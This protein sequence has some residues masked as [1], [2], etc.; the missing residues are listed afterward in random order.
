M[1]ITGSD[2]PSPTRLRSALCSVSRNTT[3]TRSPV[4][5]VCAWVGPRPVY[6]RSSRTTPWLIACAI[7]P[8][9]SLSS[10]LDKPDISP[11]RR[12]RERSGVQ[13]RRG[14]RLQHRDLF[15]QHRVLGCQINRIPAVDR[16]SVQQ[17]LDLVG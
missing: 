15:P 12:S 10:R 8:L 4:S 16:Q 9:L 5:V 17:T 3:T 7:W 1:V 13:T 14:D 2:C 11:K 6:S